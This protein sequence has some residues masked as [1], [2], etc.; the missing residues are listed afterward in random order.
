VSGLLFYL[1]KSSAKL[2]DLYD[3]DPAYVATLNLTARRE[4]F[5]FASREIFKQELLATHV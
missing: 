2:S 4:I 3:S 5:L 1:A